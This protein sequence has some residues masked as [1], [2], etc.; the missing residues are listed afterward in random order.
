MKAANSEMFL[1]SYAKMWPRSI[2]Y[3]LGD[4]KSNKLSKDVQFLDH[5]GVYILYR[6]DIPYY[7][8]QASKLGKRLYKHAF[9]TGGR[10]S[11]FWNYFSAFVI[12]VASHRNQVEGILIAAFPTA[13]SAKPRLKK[14]KLPLAI[15]KFL[16]AQLRSSANPG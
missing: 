6:D 4:E 10:Y 7:I 11:N 15:R 16:L 9:D 3:A 2:F 5:P 12:P 14:E 8:G 13:N 1:E